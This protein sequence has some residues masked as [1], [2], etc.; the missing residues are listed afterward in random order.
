MSDVTP[1]NCARTQIHLSTAIA[2]TVVIGGLT[3]LWIWIFDYFGTQAQP[4]DPSFDPTQ[5]KHMAVFL[6]VLGAATPVAIWLTF[7]LGESLARRWHERGKKSS[8]PV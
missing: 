2:L 3:G 7:A 5:Y 6:S 1:E 4:K 8:P